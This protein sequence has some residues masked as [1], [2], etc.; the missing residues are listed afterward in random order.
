MPWSPELHQAFLSHQFWTV[1]LSQ[2]CTHQDFS[3]TLQMLASQMK[4]P[5]ATTGSLTSNLKKAQQVI[6]EI[7]REA[8]QWHEEY[9]QELLEAAQ[10]NNDKG[11]QKLI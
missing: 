7:R 6:R 10:Q 4:V 1:S 9:L 3:T 5:P 8:T 2:A 11:R